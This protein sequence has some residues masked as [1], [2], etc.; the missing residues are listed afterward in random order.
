VLKVNI[1]E[2]KPRQIVAGIASRYSPDELVGKTVIVVANLTPAELR[3][4]TSEGML[5][6]AGGKEV[7]GLASIPEG[8]T[9]GTTVR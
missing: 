4:V 2:P 9:P 3:G 1:G 8:A 7:V 6:A 5:L